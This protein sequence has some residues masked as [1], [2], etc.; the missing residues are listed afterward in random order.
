MWYGTLLYCAFLI[1][2]VLASL[3]WSAA[4]VVLATPSSFGAVDQLLK[5]Q[6]WQEIATDFL[7]ALHLTQSCFGKRH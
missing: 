7:R 2:A 3:T 1:Q 6:H 4:G 5:N